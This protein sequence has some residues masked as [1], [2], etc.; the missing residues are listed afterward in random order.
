[1]TQEVDFYYDY[2]SPTAYLA[3]AQLPTLCKLHDAILNY[4]PVLLGGIF[5]A[6]GNSTPALIEPK[7]KW[8][9]DDIARHAERIGV[10]YRM[11]PFFIVNTLTMMRGA[12]W[13][14]NTGVLESYNQAMYEATW[15]NQ[16][17]TSDPDVIALVMEQASLDSRQMLEAVQDPAIKQQLIDATANAVEKGIFGVP[18]MIIDGELHFGQDRLDWIEQRLASRSAD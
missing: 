1:M 5:K 8:L 16:L 10:T 18:T 15:V 6:T 17:N 2:G 11:N 13:A 7:R 9:F 4:R 3:W 14:E 12:I